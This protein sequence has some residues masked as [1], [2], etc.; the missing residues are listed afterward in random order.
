MI[1]IWLYTNELYPSMTL[2]FLLWE[3]VKRRSLISTCSIA[4]T[5]NAPIGHFES[6]PIK[7]IKSA[8]FEIQQIPMESPHHGAVSDVTLTFDY[9]IKNIV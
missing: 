6:N 1:H 8:K 4:P 9:V 2:I 5:N 3:L 7:H